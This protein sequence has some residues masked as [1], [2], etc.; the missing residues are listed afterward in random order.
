MQ[1]V[2]TQQACLLHTYPA[3]RSAV[4]SQQLQLPGSPAQKGPSRLFSRP[5][6]VSRPLCCRIDFEY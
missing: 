4:A 3:H 1:N 5:S 2:H 6:P